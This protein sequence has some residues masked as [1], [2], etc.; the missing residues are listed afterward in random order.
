M[1]LQPMVCAASAVTN[2]TGGLLPRLFT[3]TP[4]THGKRSGNFLSHEHTLTNIFPLGSMVLCVARTFLPFLTETAMERP[5]QKERI[6][7][8]SKTAW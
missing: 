3:L 4:S 2:R 5:A 1:A 6:V 8:I 7:I